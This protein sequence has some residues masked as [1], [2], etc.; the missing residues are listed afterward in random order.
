MFSTPFSICRF[1]LLSTAL[2]TTSVHAADWPRWG[3]RDDCNMISTEKGLPESFE[4]GKKS[5]QGAGIDMSTTRNVK[6]VARLGTQ[7]YGNPTIAN[8]RISTGPDSDLP[9]H[10]MLPCAAAS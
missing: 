2:L 1:A 7:T 4:P 8:G 6:W 10:L 3:G 9:S 5:P